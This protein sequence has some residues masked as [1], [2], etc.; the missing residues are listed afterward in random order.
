MQENQVRVIL[1]TLVT[2]PVSSA[3]TR[4]EKAMDSDIEGTYW[5]RQTWGSIGTLGEAGRRR[6]LGSSMKCVRSSTSVLLT[7][8]SSSRL[9][10]LLLAA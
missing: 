6:W 9:D 5:N 8:S 3:K 10:N 2:L 4:F 1:N 7:T